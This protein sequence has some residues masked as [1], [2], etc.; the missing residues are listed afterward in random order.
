MKTHL[1]PSILLVAVSTADNAPA[2]ILAVDWGNGNYVSTTLS[3]EGDTLPADP[4]P[5]TSP[6]DEPDGPVY[7]NNPD[8]I[9]GRIYSDLI[10][11]SPDPNDGYSG[12]SATFYGGG[13]VTKANDT[14]LTN[15]GFNELSIV[16][17]GPNG[18]SIHWHVDHSDEHTFHLLLLWDKAD[19]LIDFD[20]LNSLGINDG[21]FNL[22]TA[23]SSGNHDDE[24]LRWVVRS[25]GNLWVSF[26]QQQDLD[27]ITNNASYSDTFSALSWVLYDPTTGVSVTDQLLALDFNENATPTLAQPNFS[28]ITGV[29]FYVEHEASTSPTAVHVESF[30][31]SVIPEPTLSALIAI[32]L[33]VG[34]AVRRR[35][36]TV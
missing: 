20:T 25:G 1:L 30:S 23:Q 19:F 27:I 2:S 24:Y 35:T 29:G 7:Y 12:T 33:L 36:S 32:T 10:P 15:N 5:A 6:Y 16:N 13:S 8:S 17:Q 21:E 14:G 31:F 3:L 9:T 11:F 18:D 4:A 28:A 26:K 22:T 34:T